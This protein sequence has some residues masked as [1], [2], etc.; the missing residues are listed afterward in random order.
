MWSN[1]EWSASIDPTDGRI[2]FGSWVSISDR[3]LA[4]LCRRSLISLLRCLLLFI[5]GGSVGLACHALARSC[6]WVG[7]LGMSRSTFVVAKDRRSFFSG[8]GLYD[9]ARIS[10]WLSLGWHPWHEPKRF[11]YQRR[12][13]VLFSVVQFGVVCHAS[14]HCG[15]WETTNIGKW[16]WPPHFVAKGKPTFCR[17]LNLALNIV[18][19]PANVRADGRGR[20]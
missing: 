3:V 4:F 5:I 12:M 18:N 7:T 13:G 16:T 2:A 1:C 14:A 10:V 11:F 17:S 20:E 15:G 6:L 19:N 9:L 8:S